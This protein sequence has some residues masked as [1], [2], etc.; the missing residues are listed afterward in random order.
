M[1]REP[2]REEDKRAR[3]EPLD[4]LCPSGCALR[5]GCA[6]HALHLTLC[7]L[8]HAVHRVCMPCTL[9]HA[10]NGGEGPGVGLGAREVVV[11]KGAA[12]GGFLLQQMRSLLLQQRRGVRRL[13]TD[14]YRHTVDLL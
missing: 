3:S 1:Q 7:A 14:R 4:P 12:R 9:Q 6:Q 11:V 5:R 2:P 8:Q 10:L 13:Q